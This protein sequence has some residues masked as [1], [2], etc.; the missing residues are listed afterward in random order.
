MAGPIA[1]RPAGLLDLLLTQQQG[2]NPVE[3]G[4]QLN[5][6]IDL[7][8]F[9]SAERIASSAQAVSATVVGA[10][11]TTTVP[12]GENWI[13]LNLGYQTITNAAGQVLRAGIYVRP[14]SI[15]VPV[16][17]GPTI[18][19]VGAADRISYGFDAQGLIVPSGTRIQLIIEELNLAA[20]AAFTVYLNCLYVRMET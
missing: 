8:K 19:T 6:T 17:V 16:G 9:Y 20:G 3:L 18:T 4:D 12:N 2:R 1:R 11:A 7:T 5:P 10:T 15:A 14:T 13:L